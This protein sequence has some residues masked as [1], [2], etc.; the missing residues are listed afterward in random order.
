MLLATKP[1]L[2]MHPKMTP[3]R[4]RVM[5]SGSHLLP[6]VPTQCEIVA[7]RPKAAKSCKV[8]QPESSE[9]KVNATGQIR[10]R[11]VIGIKVFTIDLLGGT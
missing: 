3:H 2:A 1:K 6:T 4:I 10:S 11:R 5:M 7:I 9:A 8:K